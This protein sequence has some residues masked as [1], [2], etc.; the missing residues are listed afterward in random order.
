MANEGNIGD[1]KFGIQADFDDKGLRQAEQALGSLG[2]TAGRSQQ[3]VSRFG[4]AAAV[5]G[6]MLIAEFATKILDTI[7]N[8]LAF[9]RAVTRAA[10]ETVEAMD[11]IAQ[12]TGVSLQQ[13]QALEPVMRRQGVNAEQLGTAFR[14]LARNIYEARDPS[15]Q[16]ATNFD[17]LGITLTGLETPAEVLSLIA[18]R[19][20]RLPDGFEKT[21]LETELLGRSGT[22]LT[23]ILNSGAAGFEASAR[24][25]LAMANVLNDDANRALLTVNDTFDDLE[26]AQDNLSKHLAVLFAPL[27]QGANEAQTALIRLSTTMVDDLT[28]ASRTLAVRFQALFG[29]LKAQAQLSVTEINKIPEIFERWDTWAAEQIAAIRKIGVAETD[30][31]KAFTGV[32]EEQLRQAELAKQAGFASSLALTQMDMGW[33]IVQ[34]SIDAYNRAQQALGQFITDKLIKAFQEQVQLQK[35]WTEQGAAGTRSLV[36]HEQALGAAYDASFA[37]AQ[38]ARQLAGTITPTELAIGA[39]GNTLAAIDA[40]IDGVKRLQLVEQ[41]AFEQR[42][43]T[44]ALENASQV[45][46]VRLV[47]EH[48]VRKMDLERQLQVLAVNRSTAEITAAAN[49]AAATRQEQQ[50]RLAALSATAEAEVRIAEGAFADVA[51]IQGLRFAAISAEL[52]RELAAVGL[53]EEQKTAIYR[54]AEADRLA[55]ARQFP[56]FWRKQLQD[57]VAGNAF[58]LSQIVTSWT[59]GLASAVVNFKN[60]G[61][62]MEQIG[63]Q[64][65][66]SLLQTILNFGVQKA[67]LLALQAGTELSI[68]S[69]TAASVGAINALKQSQIIAGETVTAGVTV[70]VWEGAAAAIVGTFGAITGA[71]MGFFTETLIPAFIAIGEA[72]ITFLTAIAKAATATIFGIPYAVAILAGVAVIGAAIGT[73]AAFAFEKG[74]IGDFGAGAPAMLHGTEAIIPLDERGAGFMADLLGLGAGGPGAGGAF[75]Q[76]VVFELDRR[77]VGRMMADE[78]IP[79]LR[80]KGLPA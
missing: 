6:G 19:I 4:T 72:I 56:T 42:M 37:A 54:K 59:G 75:R 70:S 34:A 58:S 36:E 48:A 69:S 62:A 26:Q 50:V 64:T 12:A 52:D 23:A 29:F 32:N 9:P 21:R 66:T 47:Q 65:A 40:Q 30:I 74:G 5:A 17:Q 1:V 57:L 31:K 77:V 16:A 13:F 67:A 24:E 25:A 3:A 55:V 71:I 11:S 18:E 73:I 33:K 8:V 28:V 38:R 78:L 39:Q 43:Q 44:A 53:T 49:V 10:S 61:Q 46:Q 76:T 27:V 20:S 41:A 68:A 7:T 79:V 35:F 51:R 14:I 63:R 60:F 22:Q 2:T 15:S 80:M 45:E